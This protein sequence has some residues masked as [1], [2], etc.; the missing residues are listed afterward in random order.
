M[1]SREKL[2]AALVGVV[3]VGVV[4][5]FAA[6][7]YFGAL[8]A[9]E[10]QLA[11]LKSEVNKL[12]LDQRKAQQASKRL[13][14]YEQRSLPPDAELAKILYEKWLHQVAA[15]VEPKLNVAINAKIPAAPAKGTF[16]RLNFTVTTQGELPQI[17]DFLYRIQRVDWLHRID[18]LTLVPRN[19]S[20]KIEVTL[21]ISAL[22]VRTA[23]PMKELTE[24]VAEEYKDKQLAEYRDPI[25]NRNFFSAPN[26]KPQLDLPSRTDAVIDR[27]FEQTI[28]ASDPDAFDKIASYT[29]VK[30]D[31]ETAKLDSKTGKFSWR[32]KKKGDFAFEFSVKD[33]GLPSQTSEV[34]R[35]L[36][37]VKDPKPPDVAPRKP[38]FDDAKYTVLTAVIDD[39]GTSEI[40]LNVRPKGEKRVLQ[41]GDKFEIG[42][43]KGEVSE[44]GVDDVLILVDG[45][46]R[47]LEVGQTL[48]L[49]E[50]G[51]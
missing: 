18:N 45:K 44:I 25:I 40:W 21:D 2:V 41:V 49:A 35:M 30:A 1:N 32:P 14:D 13:A 34:K 19:D 9:R 38:S 7:W 37:T 23:A 28:K 29:L 12:E 51:D 17:V 27:T 46:L 5:W 10:T 33:D 15:D 6:S 26:R 47:R 50:S 3:I 16:S 20:R 43:V 48:A 31:D 11:K 4:A 22:S 36:V 42:S 39:S 24:V 8:Q